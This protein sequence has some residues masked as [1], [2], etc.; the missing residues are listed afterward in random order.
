VNRFSL[1]VVMLSVFMIQG[2]ANQQLETRVA[3]S[4]TCFQDQPGTEARAAFLGPIA[5]ALAPKLIEG[6]VDAAAL[7]LKKAGE[8]AELAQSSGR[9][10]SR[11][12]MVTADSDLQISD[13]HRCLIV[14]RGR[15]PA[16]VASE[17][18]TLQSLVD[19]QERVFT[20]EATVQHLS[21]EPYFQLAPYRLRVGTFEGTSL[22]SPNKR[23]LSVAISMTVPGSSSPFASTVFTFE[24]IQRNTDWNPSNQAAMRKT[25]PLLALP[26]LPESGKKAQAKQEAFIAPYVLAESTLIAKTTTSPPQVAQPPN[27]LAANDVVA[28][29]DDLCAKVRS[30][31]KDFP[32][33]PISDPK[34]G[35]EI[36]LVKA[37]LDKALLNAQSPD[38][39]ES[40]ARGV[41]PKATGT[42]ESLKCQ[43]SYVP[44][45]KPNARFG[46]MVVDVSVVE[47]RQ[48]NKFAAFLGNAIGSA[49][50]DLTKAIAQQVIPE[51]KKA[52]QETKD[53]ADRSAY[54]EVI[55]ADLAVTQSEQELVELQ[56]SGSP[57]ASGLT[58][59]RA[60]VI[61]A[62]IA[63]NDAYRTAG[64]P[65]PYPELG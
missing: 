50:A 3:W 34:C 18:G 35:R 30:Y 54:R 59:A 58:T 14:S 11:P 37:E 1:L 2:C 16:P 49:K 28:K 8:R 56:A 31:N 61:K 52:V 57:S 20:F 38:A 45:V 19:V 40:W 26:P 46:H 53:A 25:S 5:V 55:L 51:Q 17:E 36:T 43:A 33:S 42:G 48:G 10:I 7:A 21:G 64:L 4:S 39:L 22:W 24:D 9:A 6:A 12:Y 23:E 63:A 13:E 62:K 29:T 44:P 27:P 41:C 15:F 60:L 47:A 65:L 32:K